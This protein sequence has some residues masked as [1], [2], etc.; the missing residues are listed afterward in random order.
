M[1]IHG[2]TR[3]KKRENKLVAR[4]YANITNRLSVQSSSLA[5]HSGV[6]IASLSYNG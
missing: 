5:T 6:I 2:K 1:L 4:H 3:L